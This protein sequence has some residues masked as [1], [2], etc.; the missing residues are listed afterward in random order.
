MTKYEIGFKNGDCVHVDPSDSDRFMREISVAFSNFNH[1][2]N[3]F[4]H[5]NVILNLNEVIFVIPSTK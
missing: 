4:Q 2:I 3:L 5:D 1:G